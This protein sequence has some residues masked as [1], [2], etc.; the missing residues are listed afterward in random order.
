MWDTY[1]RNV[2]VLIVDDQDFIRSLLR[3]ILDVLGCTYISDC[4]DGASARESIRDNP[5]DLLIVDWEMA[6]MDGIELVQKVRSDPTSRTSSC[7]SS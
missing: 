7:P 4:A 2:R 3:H 5:P 6:P 1:L